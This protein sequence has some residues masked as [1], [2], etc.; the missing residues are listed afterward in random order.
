M[1][2]K[3]KSS[4][5]AVELD[6]RAFHAELVGDAGQFLA[7][8]DVAELRVGVLRILVHQAINRGPLIQAFMAM[9]SGT[10]VQLAIHGPSNDRSI[11]GGSSRSN[12]G[13]PSPAL[14]ELLA[15]HWK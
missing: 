6:E 7:H 3:R 4:P 11:P 2:S 1:S 10:P 5:G 8:A 12:R 15:Q 14:D 9:L 13:W